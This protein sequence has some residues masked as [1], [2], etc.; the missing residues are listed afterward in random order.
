MISY[1]RIIEAN[2]EDTFGRISEGLKEEGYVLLSFVDVKE[3]LTK[4]FGGTNKGY[5]ILNV[6]K[7][8]AAKELIG[9]NEDYGLFLPCKM[10]LI[11]KENKTRVVIMRVSELARKYLGSDGAKV[12]GYEEELISLINR[13]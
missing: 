6:C 11:E 8:Q 13:L 1:E 2:V 12:S 4:N 5:Y 10:L 3:I 7:P 9:E